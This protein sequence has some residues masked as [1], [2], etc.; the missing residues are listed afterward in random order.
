MAH[1]SAETIEVQVTHTEKPP[2]TIAAFESHTQTVS[3]PS[4]NDHSACLYPSEKS[5]NKTSK[6]D[7]KTQDYL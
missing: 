5:Q 3:L 2:E 6:S 4:H 7:I 1:F